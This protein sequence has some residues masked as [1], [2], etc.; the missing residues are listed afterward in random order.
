MTSSGFR[1]IVAN[2]GLILLVATLLIGGY[3]VFRSRPTDLASEQ[4]LYDL[5]NGGQPTIVELYSNL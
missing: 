3:L 2:Y 4:A 5:L 1:D